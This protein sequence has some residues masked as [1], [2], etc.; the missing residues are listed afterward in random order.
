MMIW[1]K[2]VGGEGRRG[3]EGEGRGGEERVSKFNF[4]GNHVSLFLKET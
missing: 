1:R 4:V 2:E 3:R